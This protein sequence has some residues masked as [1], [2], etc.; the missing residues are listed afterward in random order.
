LE[1]DVTHDP[2]SVTPRKPLTDKQRLQLFIRHQGICCLCG[3]KIDGVKEMWDEHVNP[4][5]RDG[6]NEA[7]NRA[8]AHSKCARLKTKQES[9][10]R[11]KGRDVAQFHFGA[12]RAKT[13]PMPF[14]RRSKLKKKFNGDV[15]ER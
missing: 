14:G 2:Y 7:E 12:K 8:P 6:D 5:W 9:T 4:L 10:E 15:V 1:R 11:A 13:K 3:L